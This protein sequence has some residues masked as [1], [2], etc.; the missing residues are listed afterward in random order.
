[1]SYSPYS[2]FKVGACL[3]CEDGTTYRGCNVENSAFTVGVCA[4]RCAY[5][6]AISEGKLKYKAIAVAAYQEKAFTT[7]CGACRQFISEFGNIPIYLVKP[8]E[9]NVFVTSVE[10]LLPHS[11]QTSLDN[12]FK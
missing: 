3:L 9:D 6:K 4:E 12:L 11:F 7:P 10:E 5:V 1:M 8:D 2:N